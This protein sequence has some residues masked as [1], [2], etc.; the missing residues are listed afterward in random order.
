MSTRA[1]INI[2]EDGEVFVRIYNQSGGCPTGLGQELAD[3]L[4]G[5]EIVDGL[6]LEAQEKKIANGMGCLAAQLIKHLKE[7]PGGIYIVPPGDHAQEFEYYILEIEG[8]LYI[9][10]YNN[11][12]DRRTDPIP[13]DNYFT[14][15][16]K[17]EF[18]HEGEY[19]AG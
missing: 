14:E 6:S 13:V 7:E 5:F 15:I 19:N 18:C 3:F 8:K 4:V 11:L 10:V 12:I 17:V 16:I 1:I 2:I 9:V